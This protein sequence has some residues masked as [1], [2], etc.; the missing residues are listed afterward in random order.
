MAAIQYSNFLKNIERKT[1]DFR[2]LVRGP[3]Q[4]SDKIVIIGT[5]EK[6]LDEIEDPFV[7]WNPYFAKIIKAVAGGGATAIGIDFLQTISLKDKVAGTDHDGIM[8]DALMEAENVIMINLLRWDTTINGLKALNPLPRYLYAADPDNVGFS[9]LTIDRDGCVRR[10][11]LLMS[12]T[13][14][15]VYGYIG[16]KVIAKALNSPIEKKGNH[17][18]VGD[19]TIPVNEYNEMR[20]N[21]AGPSGTFP[22]LSFYEVWKMASLENGDFFREHFQGKIVLIGPG[23][24]YSQDFK[25]TPY[26]R[27]RYYS[28][29]PQTLGV[30]I[31]ANTIN[32]IVQ[33]N[34]IIPLEE[35]QTMLIIL[36]LGIMTSYISFRLP[37]V[38]GGI[39]SFSLLGIYVF[40]CIAL[41]AYYNIFLQLI[42][43]IGSIPL[44]YTAVF[45]YRYTIE[46]KEK[47]MV[48]KIFKRYVSREVVDEIL[49]S[50]E[51]LR[52]GGNR[53]HV[54]ILFAD[55]RGFTSLS[56]NKD[57]QYIVSL[58]NSYFSIMADI[59]LK[60]KGTLDKYLGDG[61]LAFFGA[62]VERDD[63]AESAVRSAIEMIAGLDK[64]NKD[65]NIVPPL[66]IGIGIH[67][68]SAVV[69]NVGS[70]LKMEYTVIG[71]TVNTASRIEGLTKELKASILITEATYSQLKNN[72][73]IVP[74]KEVLLRGKTKPIK[75]YRIE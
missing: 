28:G 20:I 46:D 8:A 35:W 7:F 72:Y 13:E 53:V 3:I 4:V 51:S 57:P 59:I 31:I 42:C 15:N 34:F 26:Y 55:I 43:P 27:S 24:I 54:S 41:F 30:E 66:K 75:L 45:A 38:I 49:K 63:H 25:P 29:T 52:L 1:Y 62:P 32:T 19:Y 5:D 70:E 6:A 14:N 11:I 47:R 2:F 58:L 36:F 68:G 22:M 18:I 64:L 74:E 56:E 61:I 65:Q 71:D 21:F 50:P 37:P 73:N 16:L 67:S 60:N 39:A 40:I 44:V 23:N 10:Q 48:K 17:L 33:Q 12:D 9:N 69:G